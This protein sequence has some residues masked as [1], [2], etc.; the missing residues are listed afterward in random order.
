M[1]RWLRT[2]MLFEAAL[3]KPDATRD[4]FLVEACNDDTD[5]LGD[6][7]SLVTAH[8]A[9]GEFIER[10][11]IHAIPEMSRAHHDITNPGDTLILSQKIPADYAL[12]RRCGIGGFGEVW[13]V[14]DHASVYR[15]MKIVRMDQLAT[16][17]IPQRELQALK[18][19]CRKV[20]HHENLIQILH[21]SHSDELLCYTMELADDLV[22]RRPVRDELSDT[23]KP[24]TLA[25]VLAAG[26]LNIDTAV[27]VI[28][29]L[30]RGL[31][32]LHE[33]GLIHRDIKPAN[34]LFAGRIVKLADV[35][36]IGG[37]GTRNSIVGTPQFMPPDDCM[38]ATADTYALGKVLYSMLTGGNMS[39][40]PNLPDDGHLI[41][42]RID[43]HKL[44][45]F[46]VQACAATASERFGSAAAMLKA[47][48]HCSFPLLDSP[49]RNLGEDEDVSSAPSNNQ[50][51]IS[52]LRSRAWL[53]GR[54][55]TRGHTPRGDEVV[56]ALIDRFI[57]IVPWL[58]L[59][60]LGLFL[61]GRLT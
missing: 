38:D 5:L 14:R 10:P 47:L 36:L 19:Y 1:D 51:I 26:R 4:H 25:G 52:D 27:E 15:A 59:L 28:L 46:L 18:R 35:S 16:L 34:I 13:I 39:S 37:R 22:S 24:M 2:K 56:W 11:A 45:C 30:L 23:Y 7:R 21:I 8:E 57:K 49:L 44:Q 17:G 9:A 40:F 60:I 42:A 43:I 53:G 61:I 31:A 3:E 12:I 33:A 54:S 58:V 50:P 55:H 32:A 41:S 29:R 6:V 20:P 48:W